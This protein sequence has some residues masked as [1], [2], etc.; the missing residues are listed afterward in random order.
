MKIYTKT[1]DKGKTSLFNGTRVSKNNIRLETYGTMDELSS[2]LGITASFLQKKD[3]MVSL[4]ASIQ[5]DLLDVG[6]YLADPDTKVSE[7]FLMHIDERIR[8]FET[9][10]DAMTVKLPPLTNFI[11]FTGGN[12]AAFLQQA[13]SVTRRTERRLVAL[14]QK[15]SVDSSF[16][17]YFNRLSDLLFTMGRYANQNKKGREIIWKKFS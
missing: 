2:I 17:R 1:G 9:T 12:A 11:I 7:K 6:A 10:I 4:I 14:S 13:R 3:A 16:I 8:F 5:K 15:A